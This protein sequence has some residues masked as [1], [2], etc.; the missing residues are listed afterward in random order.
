MVIA[1]QITQTNV[2]TR[3]GGSDI[4]GSSLTEIVSQVVRENEPQIFNTCPKPKAPF[5][6]LYIISKKYQDFDKLGHGCQEL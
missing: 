3:E 4:L 5:I 1:P 2:A 6:D